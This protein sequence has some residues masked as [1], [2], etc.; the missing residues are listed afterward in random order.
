MTRTI[1]ISVAAFVLIAS[2]W[3]INLVSYHPADQ[4]VN[5]LSPVTLSV[6]DIDHQPRV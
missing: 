1:V 4:G 2:A 3:T 5:P 6:G